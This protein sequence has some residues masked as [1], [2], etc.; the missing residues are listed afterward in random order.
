MYNIYIFIYE[1]CNINNNSAKRPPTEAET[2]RP[3]Q[4]DGSQLVS[5]CG[6]LMRF[7]VWLSGICGGFAFLCVLLFA[8]C[9]CVWRLVALRLWSGL[10]CVALHLVACFA[11]LRARVLFL[12][13]DGVTVHVLFCYV[14][15][16]L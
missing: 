13:F 8:V 3:R 14:P 6:W 16:G 10:A 1:Y 9:G 2:M 5:V 4:K 7:G 11:P 15:A 12:P